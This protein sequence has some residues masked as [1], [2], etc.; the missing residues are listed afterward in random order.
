ME[1]THRPRRLRRTGPVRSL[2]RETELCPQHLI[3]PI[4]VT[5][6]EHVR[7]PINTMPGQFRLSI[8][9]VV[10][11]CEILLK[12]G[13]GAV[14]LF[15]YSPEK[16]ETGKFAWDTEGLIPRCVRALKAAH[17]EVCVQ[18]D[19]ALDPYTATCSG[20]FSPQGAD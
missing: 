20:T 15:G 10:Q 19:V 17:P 9:E 8:D 5:K 18:T 6:G 7:D 14:N 4:F 16:D 3:Y 13:V 1:L 11:E 12:L 2:I